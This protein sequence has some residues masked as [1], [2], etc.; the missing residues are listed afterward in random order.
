MQESLYDDNV[1]CGCFSLIISDFKF[2]YVPVVFHDRSGLGK[3]IE[4]NILCL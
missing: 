3:C 4:L 2:G 1:I